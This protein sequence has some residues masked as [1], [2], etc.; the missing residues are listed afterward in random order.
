ML[1]I[2]YLRVLIWAEMGVRGIIYLVQRVRRGEM[3]LRPSVVFHRGGGREYGN[4]SFAG[5]GSILGFPKR[6]AKIHA[7][8]DRFCKANGCRAIDRPGGFGAC[9]RKSKDHQSMDLC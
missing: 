9:A 4:K 1:W 5:V 3:E 6:N 8:L 7:S 2:R